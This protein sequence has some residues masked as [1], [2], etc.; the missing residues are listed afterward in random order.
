[1]LPACLAEML[2]TLWSKSW[3]LSVMIGSDQVRLEMFT[4]GQFPF[5]YSQLV[6][7]ACPEVVFSYLIMRGLGVLPDKMVTV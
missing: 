2:L 5:N 6:C 7:M 1:M 3:I 4:T